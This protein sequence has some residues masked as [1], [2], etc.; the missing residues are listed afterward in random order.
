VDTAVFRAA[1]AAYEVVKLND[2]SVR[3]TG[4]DGT[5]RLINIEQLEFANGTVVLRQLFNQAPVVAA[6][7]ADRSAALGSPVS[8]QL[9]EATFTDADADETLTWSVSGLPKWLAFDPATRTFSGTPGT[10]D[11]RDYNI[12]VTV[13]DSQGAQAS[14][15]FQLTV[16]KSNSAPVLA[17]ALPDHTVTSGSSFNVSVGN[18]RFTDPDPGDTLTYSA[19]LADGSSL[20]SWISFNVNTRSFTGVASGAE[21][22]DIRVTVTDSSGETVSDV[23]RL[24]VR[25]APNP[26]PPPPAPIVGNSGADTLAGTVG[27]DVIQGLAGADFVSGG[28]GNDTIE[29]G[30]GLDV[31]LGNTGDDVIYGGA[32]QDILFGGQ[33]NDQ[34]FGGTENDILTG[35]RGN[36]TLWGGDAGDWAGGSAGDDVVYGE[37]GS[38]LLWGM[39]GTTP[40]TAGSTPTSSTAAP[41][42]T[43]CSAGTPTTPCWAARA[44]TRWRAAT[45]ST[46]CW[47][48]PA[49]T[50]CSAAWARTGCSAG[51]TRTGWRAATAT[52][53]C[54]ATSATTPWWAAQARTGSPSAPRAGPTWCW[55]S[56]AP[57]ET[58]SSCWPTPPSAS[59]PAAATP[60]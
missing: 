29:G 11:A 18:G 22:V 14:D 31:L 3:V 50:S 52:T 53:G 25:A 46:C 4:P 43:G 39:T 6:P 27:D 1:Q 38:D 2:G 28:A 40:S 44:P 17:S 5:D 30:D 21:P 47:A 56:P 36:D 58:G 33:D 23:F 13:T 7:I 55:T 10:G 51:A 19:R 54:R 57:P 32:D 45:A 41:T 34:L 16:N 20:P 35:D 8:F 15:A 24:N 59:A 26:P 42:P 9:A 49:P 37:A 60:W 12:R 48:T